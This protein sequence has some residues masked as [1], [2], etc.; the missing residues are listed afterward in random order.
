MAYGITRTDKKPL[1]SHEL[2]MVQTV[3][4]KQELKYVR[5][6]IRA[7]QTC[8]LVMPDSRSLR[9]W[10]ADKKL[11]ANLRQQLLARAGVETTVNPLGFRP[12]L[13]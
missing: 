4:R 10:R 3:A 5:K 6:A 12:A 1:A 9:T 7:L 13:V 11:K 8:R 2:L